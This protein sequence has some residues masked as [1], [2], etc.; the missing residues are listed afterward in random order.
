M[1]LQISKSPN[2]EN[3]YIVKSVYHKGKRSNKVVE[4]LGNL[5]DVKARC[6]DQD[7]YEWAKDYATGLTR[8]EKEGK[9]LKILAEYDPN[10]TIAPE[11]QVLFA[12]GY[13]FLQKIYHQLGLHKICSK[14]SNEYKFEYDLDKILSRLIIGRILYP[15]SKRGTMEYSKRL[16]EAP[17][18]ELHQ[19]YRAL[20]VLAKENEFIQSEL[21]KNSLKLSKRNDRILYYDCTN[22]F[23]EIEEEDDFRKYGYSKEHKPNPIV[24]MGMFLDGSGIPLAFSIS[25]GNTNEQVTL[26]PLEKKIIE[27]FTKASFVVCTD[28]GL[29][30]VAN[31]KF[32]D[33][34]G[35]AFITTQS[36]KNMKNY[37]K[38]WALSPDKWKLSEE[39]KTYNLTD[40]LSDET[41]IDKYYNR[42]FFKERWI[43]EGD[44]QQRFIVTFSIK[45]MVYQ[46]EL[47][48]AQ[49][50]RAQRMV[51]DPKK[52]S[53][54]RQTDPKRLIKEEAVTKDG[55][56]AEEKSY[57]ID[58]DK[59]LEECKYDGFY[60]VATNL[61]DDAESIVK[62][63]SKRWEIEES[64]RIM[65]SEFA[66]RPVYLSRKDRI[67]AH[68]LTCFLSLTIYRYLEKKLGEEYT[69]CEILKTLKSMDFLHLEAEGY[70]PAYT[71]TSITDK[72]HEAFGFRTDSQIVTMRMMKEILRETKK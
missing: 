47:R 65:K 21:Y 32:N 46:R 63:N 29:G 67:I 16:I 43:N 31:R 59:F 69:C 6:G 18:F 10:K 45:Y 33:I 24:Q 54:K 72:L 64:F 20:E 15:T 51:E 40:I 39:D 30:G 4:R 49:L 3:F 70:I 68:F 61:E 17:G 12:G 53:K 48:Q 58:N 8:L 52:I 37:Q 22:Y 71:K 11:K 27:D 28:A 56:I 44:L 19:I 2:A 66:A 14:I 25:P 60:A 1:R 62:I 9:E 5:E 36:I 26:K 55:E 42:L 41:L 7:P 57:C 50:L 23:F 34:A 13:L 38:D 35:R